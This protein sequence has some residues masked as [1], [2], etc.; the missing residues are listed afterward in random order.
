MEALD[1]LESAP[2]YGT[3]TELFDASAEDVYRYVHRRCRDH[4]LAEDVTQ[5]VFM[6]A[7]RGHHPGEISVG[8]LKRAARNRLIDVLRRQA[9]YER[10]LRVVGVDDDEGEIDVADRLRVETALSELSVEHRLVLTLH[11]LD[12][13]TVGAIASDMG[14]SNKTVEALITRARRQLRT[15]LGDHDG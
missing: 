9:N 10:K 1:A 13:M 7:V 4:G 6:T 5:D 11:Y 14:R 8:W 3:F 2:T 12:G 15:Q